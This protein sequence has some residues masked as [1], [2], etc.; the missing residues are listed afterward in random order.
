MRRSRLKELGTLSGSYKQETE[1]PGDKP[2]ASRALSTYDLS[3]PKPGS[4]RSLAEARGQG[5]GCWEA[6]VKG[7]YGDANGA[8]E[9]RGN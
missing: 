4:L 1:M 7:G 5:I 9:A 6:G 8:A 3:L 2:T